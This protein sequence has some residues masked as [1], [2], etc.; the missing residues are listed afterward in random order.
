MA[1]LDKINYKG[2]LYDIQDSKLKEDLGEWISSVT[3]YSGWH[4]IDVVDCFSSGDKV[5]I[6]AFESDDV[7]F[8]NIVGYLN[9]SGTTLYS[10]ETSTSPWIITLSASFDTI[11]VAYRCNSIANV[12]MSAIIKKLDNTVSGTLA[13]TI[14]ATNSIQTQIDNVIDSPFVG[15]INPKFKG[16]IGFEFLITDPSDADYSAIK[17]QKYKITN[18]YYKDAFYL[19]LSMLRYYNGEWVAYDNITIPL[20]SA[21]TENALMFVESNYGRFRMAYLPGLMQAGRATSVEYIVKN[22]AIN[23]FL[24]KMQ[25]EINRYVPYDSYEIKPTIQTRVT[26]KKDGT[27]DYSTISSAY[28]AI[29]GKS[30][31]FNQYEVCVYPGVYE[32]VNLICPAYTH[33]HGMFP[34]TV[35]VTSEGKT[36]TQ[37]VFDQTSKPSRLSNMKIISATGYCIHIDN[38]LIHS[39]VNEN[40]YCKKAYSSDV[41]DFG[42]ESLSSPRV[43]IGMGAQPAGMKIVFNG[44]TFE[45][46][47]VVCH[48]NSSSDENADFSLVF[49]NCKVVNARI[50]LNKA[51]ND[52]AALYGNWL[53]SINNLAMARGQTKPGIALYYGDPVDGM[54]YNFGW[55]IIGGGI[56]TAIDFMKDLDSTAPDCWENIELIEKTYIQA[57]S[58]ITK[59][60]WI[61]DSMIPATANEKGQDIVGIALADASTGDTVPIWVGNAFVIT[62][63]DGEYGIGSDGTL[64]SGATEKIGKIINNVFYRY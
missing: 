10:N 58:S 49:N 46:G 37:P 6:H 3:N 8:Y 47:A 16:I 20:A 12:T 17:N 22:T 41:S 4:Q 18:I 29:S 9:G 33:T 44:C 63:T 2:T 52:G 30:S 60:Q 40:L 38:P 23:P 53:C 28:S 64:S 51:G 27:G 5:Y 56:N 61:T 55:Q 13:N 14:N 7:Q 36:G 21:P 15:Q 34:N 32:E 24:T 25:D 31:F 43:I 57:K 35:V 54:N 11:S 62:G 39:V 59:G 45:D 48:T 50:Q 42:W 26:V 19:Y 1:Y